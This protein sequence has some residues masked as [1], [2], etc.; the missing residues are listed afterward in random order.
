MRGSVGGCRVHFE[1][2]RCRAGGHAGTLCLVQPNRRPTVHGLVA[3]FRGPSDGATR[4]RDRG[5]LGRGAHGGLVRRG[6]NQGRSKSEHLPCPRSPTCC[7]L[8]EPHRP[9]IFA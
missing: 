5:G 8:P 6:G 4:L 7:C 9:P 1:G 2:G 3:R